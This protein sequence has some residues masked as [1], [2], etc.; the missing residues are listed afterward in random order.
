MPNPGEQSAFEL[1][2]LMRELIAANRELVQELRELRRAMTKTGA[3]A[4][5]GEVLRFL[6]ARN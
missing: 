1:L 6:K 5:F 4:T 3:A 2:V